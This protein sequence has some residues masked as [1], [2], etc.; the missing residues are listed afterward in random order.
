MPIFFCQFFPEILHEA[1]EL[2][3]RQGSDTSSEAGSSS[4]GGSEI[5]AAISHR[6]NRSAAIKAAMAA[7]KQNSGLHGHHFGPTI[8][9]VNGVSAS[10]TG[11]HNL[12]R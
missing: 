10:V 6:S 2:W 11:H 3:I 1:E 9:T 12:D 5:S 7:A 8:I 4:T